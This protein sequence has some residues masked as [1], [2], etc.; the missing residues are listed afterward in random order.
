MGGLPSMISLLAKH[1]RQE[2][3]DEDDREQD[4]ERR[5]NGRES[6]GVDP[7][8]H[9]GAQQ[10]EGAAESQLRQGD[11]GR[12]E[13][14]GDPLVERLHEQHPDDAPAD[15]EQDPNRIPA[16]PRNAAIP[17]YAMTGSTPT[18]AS[19]GRRPYLVAPSAADLAAKP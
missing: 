7:I 11:H 14:G 8:A 6:P 12:A 9:E 10:T 4:A 15:L 2:Q 13:R 1:Q 3:A 19:N 17:K 5:Q 18:T 16:Q